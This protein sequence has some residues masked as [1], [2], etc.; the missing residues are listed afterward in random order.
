M[1]HTIKGFSVV[2][3]EK[4]DVFLEFP[5]F[6]QDPMNVGNL[7]SGSSVFCKP[8]LYIW[9]FSV[10]ILL[11]PI[12]RDFEHWLASM[13]NAY[14][15]MVVWTFFGIVLLWDGDENCP[16]PVP[17]PLLISVYNFKLENV[18]FPPFSSISL[19]LVIWVFLGFDTFCHFS[20]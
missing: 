15:Y 19:I 13:W 12:L 1:I 5:C 9:K 11:K 14:D 17:W 6:F 3:E 16:F 18:I 10:H 20:Y 2:N 4:A 8:S 7:I